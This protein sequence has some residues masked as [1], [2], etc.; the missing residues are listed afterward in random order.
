MPLQMAGPGIVL[1]P[2]LYPPSIT[3]NPPE[4]LAKNEKRWNLS[5][6]WKML[7]TDKTSQVRLVWGDKSWPDST[8]TKQQPH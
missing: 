2:H 5:W 6:G 1:A 3:R 7:G 8:T 4:S